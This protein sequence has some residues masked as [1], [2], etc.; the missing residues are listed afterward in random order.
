MTPTPDDRREV[1]SLAA[2]TAIVLFLGMVM[3]WV[4]VLA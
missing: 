2:L 1:S 4:R 3:I